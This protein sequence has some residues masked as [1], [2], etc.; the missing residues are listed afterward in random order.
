VRGRADEVKEMNAFDPSRPRVIVGRATY[1][2]FDDTVADGLP[3]DT[4]EIG[5][6]CSI[7]QE[8]RIIPSAEHPLDLPTT[9][10]MRTLFTRRDSGVNWDAFAKGPTRI[11]ND[12]WIG[13]RAVIVS[14]VTVGDG[15]VIGAGAVVGRD[16]PPYA[17][18]AG[19]PASVVRMRFDAP[20]VERLLALRWW[21]WSDEKIRAFE[22]YFYADI[23]TF[24][25]AAEAAAELGLEA[26]PPVAAA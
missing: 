18:V 12:V 10:P 24:L 13:R 16:V 11:G 1:G 2:V 15:A 17:V 8:T 6:F 4:V 14:G 25:D 20:T 19:N 26:P 5:Q 9:F 7:G 3:T 23:E 21:D 22:P